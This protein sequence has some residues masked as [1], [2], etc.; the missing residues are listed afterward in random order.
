MITSFFVS[1]TGIGEAVG[2]MASSSLE[3]YFGFTHAYETFGLTLLL[4]T[5]LYYF[6]AGATD[7]CQAADAVDLN[8]DLSEIRSMRSGMG[9]TRYM[10]C[11]F[12]ETRPTLSLAEETD[13]PSISTK[14]F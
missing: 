11:N 7:I 13:L 5:T 3:N 6:G 10:A 12:G 8:T 4:F 9:S 14:D 2:P 1:A